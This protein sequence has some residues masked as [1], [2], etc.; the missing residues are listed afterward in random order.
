MEMTTRVS[1]NE[2]QLLLHCI[3]LCIA[4][5]RVDVLLSILPA[6]ATATATAPASANATTSTSKPLITI[7]QLEPFQRLQLCWI[8]CYEAFQTLY[9]ESMNYLEPTPP[10]AS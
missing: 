4:T 5:H 9:S 6:A 8:T 10:P 1:E 2:E 7:H 3:S